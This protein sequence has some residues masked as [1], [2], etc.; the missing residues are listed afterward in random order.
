MQEKE[1]RRKLVWAKY[2]EKKVGELRVKDRHACFPNPKSNLYIFSRTNHNKVKR[3]RCI[4]FF[5]KNFTTSHS[6][7]DSSLTTIHNA[8]R[9]R[10]WQCWS[11]NMDDEVVQRVFHEGGRDYFQQQ[12]STSSSSSSILQSL[13]LHV[14]YTL[15][16]NFI[17]RF[18]INLFSFLA[19]M[20][21][22][23][24]QRFA[25]NLDESNIYNNISV[26]V[27]EYFTIFF[28]P[29]FNFRDR[30]LILSFCL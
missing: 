1:K 29:F 7:E 12:P 8:T 28:L 25:C 3:S 27:Y 20:M 19:D 16:S 6:T 21:H 4:F 14:V 13:P 17:F 10:K 15:C 5:A 9:N 18:L 2:V 22:F 24:S 23:A 30:N 26:E 11:G